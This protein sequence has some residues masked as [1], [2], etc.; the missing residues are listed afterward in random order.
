MKQLALLL[1]C[2]LTACSSGSEE[3]ENNNTNVRVVTPAK[4]SARV[5]QYPEHNERSSWT[6][7]S[8]N[9]QGSQKSAV[10]ISDEIP[11]MPAAAKNSSIGAKVMRVL[12]VKPDDGYDLSLISPNCKTMSYTV[13]RRF[14]SD[15]DNQVGGYTPSSGNPNVFRDNLNWMCGKENRANHMTKGDYRVA[16]RFA[17]DLMDKNVTVVPFTSIPQRPGIK[18]DVRSEENAIIL[19]YSDFRVE[20]ISTTNHPGSVVSG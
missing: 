19:G 5:Q 4:G 18:Y 14:S 17:R 10:L 12:E 2:F 16:V 11:I 8:M 15:R 9:S 13:H 6:L 1:A 3:L 20:R 7:V